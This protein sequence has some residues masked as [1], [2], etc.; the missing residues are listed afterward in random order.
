MVSPS[1]PRR[2][3]I[4]NLP[5]TSL[6]KK[7]SD[8]TRR[9]EIVGVARALSSSCDSFA[10]AL[11]ARAHGPGRPASG[12]PAG[13]GRGA[14]RVRLGPQRT[15]PDE[16]AAGAGPAPRADAPVAVVRTA[17]D[18][19][20]SVALGD[21]AGARHIR[22]AHVVSRVGRG[23][24]ADASPKR[25]LLADGVTLF[26]LIEVDD[27]GKPRWFSD[28]GQVRWR[29][30][31]LATAPLAQAPVVELGWKRVEPAAASMSNEASGPLPLRADPLRRHAVA[32]AAAA[33]SSPTST[34]R[35]RPIT[36]TASARCASSSSRAG[37]PRVASARPRGAPRPR[38]RRPDRRGACASRSAATTATSATSPRCSASPTSGR[39]AGLGDASTR[40]SGSRARTAPTSSSTARAALG[41]P[42]AVHLDRRP[43]AAHPAARRA[44]RAAPTAS[45]ATPPASPLP[46]TQPGDLVLFPRHVGA[47]AVDR[48]TLGVLDD[49]RPLM[50]TLFD[51]PKQQPIA[52]RYADKPVEILRWNGLSNRTK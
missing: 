21:A 3:A 30:K 1:M 33:R 36:A 43:A 22:A 6:T 9:R 4:V 20:G 45:T 10:I 23:G 12:P 32:G 40:A 17:V 34:R 29:G 37:R 48:G 15:E 51:S 52:T 47:L 18:S 13:R 49:R 19:A 35:S 50:H 7:Y 8:L 42:L 44:A 41:K 5:S 16:R 38:L 11:R 28:A 24:V 14:D 39:R 2:R 31:L 46:F 25:A 27:G 26:A